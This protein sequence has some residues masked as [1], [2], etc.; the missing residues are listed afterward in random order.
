M[1]EWK[2][3]HGTI[4]STKPPHI[5]PSQEDLDRARKMRGY[6]FISYVTDYDCEEE[7]P[8]WYIV[9]D[10]P[11]ILEEIPSNRR[12]KIK[13]GLRYVTVRKI[14]CRDYGEELY[15]CYQK[16][17]ERYKAHTGHISKERFLENLRNDKNEYYGAFFLET[18]QLV[19]YIKNIVY[20]DC[21]SLSV[22]KYDPDYLKYQV[23]AALTYCVVS[24]YI[25]ERHFQYVMDGHRAIRHKTNVQEYLEYYFGFRKAYCRLN[26]IYSPSM[27]V[28][29]NSLY[30]FRKILDK[31]AGNGVFLNNIASVLKMEE[32]RRACRKKGH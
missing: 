18:N 9:K 3:Y 6:R 8:W 30:P 20:E 13:K 14:N 22:I 28:A 21:V 2:R 16:A 11:I 7:L 19:A 12:Y 10:S 31:I 4:V 26:L 27:K 5:E 15:S 29:V 25:N 24:D 32:I 1:I 23:S 17:Q